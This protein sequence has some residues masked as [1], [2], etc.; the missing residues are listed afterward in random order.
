M[1]LELLSQVEIHMHKWSNAF[2]KSLKKIRID[3][4]NKVMSVQCTRYQLLIFTLLKSIPFL[5]K[6]KK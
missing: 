6:S 3:L 5:T 2:L 1:S 4:E